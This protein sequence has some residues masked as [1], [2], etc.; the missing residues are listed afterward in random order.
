MYIA[1]N[2]SYFVIYMYLPKFIKSGENLTNF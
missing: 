2:F 1:Y